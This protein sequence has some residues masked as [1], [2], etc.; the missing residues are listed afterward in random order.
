MNQPQ[1]QGRKHAGENEQREHQRNLEEVEL[2]LCQNEA[3]RQE[4]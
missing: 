1:I 4:H 3:K 2:E